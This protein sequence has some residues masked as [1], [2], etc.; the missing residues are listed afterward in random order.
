MTAETKFEPP[1]ETPVLAAL[2]KHA[3]EFVEDGPEESLPQNPPS[4]AASFPYY[5][6]LGSAPYPNQA[7]E[8]VSQYR[9]MGIDAYWVEVELSI[10][11]WYRIYT[12]YFSTRE[13]SEKFKGEK[14][15]KNAEVKEVP[16]TNLIGT[17]ASPQEAQAQL[18][19]LKRQGFSPYVVEAPPGTYRVLIGAF[20]SDDRA[21]RRYA[22]LKE[23][24]I[25][26]EIVRR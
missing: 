8:G 11:V 4:T 23:K 26:S 10:G 20:Y 9:R 21:R 12:G 24:G 5:L 3:I 16:Y 17:Y 18:Q 22:E 13:Q 7:E 1:S 14:G 2:A 15:L 19:G 6:I 25:R